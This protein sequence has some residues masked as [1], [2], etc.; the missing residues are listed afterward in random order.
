VID[1]LVKQRWHQLPR[2][3][4][5]DAAQGAGDLGAQRDLRGRCCVPQAFLA[6]MTEQESGSHHQCLVYLAEVLMPGMLSY[7]VSKI[8]L[9]SSPRGW[10]PSLQQYHIAVTP[11][12]S[13]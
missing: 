10:P 13:R 2:S 11:C 3:L 7:A 1:I 6:R 12:A 9:G 5:P 8:A 4:P